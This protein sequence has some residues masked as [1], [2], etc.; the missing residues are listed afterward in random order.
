MSSLKIEFD[1]KALRKIE[2]IAKDKAREVAQSKDYVIDCPHC[3]RP[4]HVYAGENT[5]IYCGKP[6]ELTLDIQF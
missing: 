4:I 1:K 2:D 3:K 5:C 6:V